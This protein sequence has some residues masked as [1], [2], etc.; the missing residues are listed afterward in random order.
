MSRKYWKNDCEIDRRKSMAQKKKKIE[1][2][3]ALSL[4]LC[5]ERPRRGTLR[6]GV[7]RRDQRAGSQ[8]WRAT[9]SEASEE[10]KG[11]RFE[12][13]KH[14]K[15]A[16]HQRG[17]AE[18]KRRRCVFP[19]SLSLSRALAH[20][21]LESTRTETG[22]CS[23]HEERRTTRKRFRARV[24]REKK[25]EGERRETMNAVFFSLFSPL[26]CASL[27][28]QLTFFFLPVAIVTRGLRSSR[29]PQEGK[30]E[31]MKEENRGRAFLQGPPSLSAPFEGGDESR[32]RNVGR[33]SS[34]VE[35]K[36]RDQGE[37][38]KSLNFF[39]LSSP[40]S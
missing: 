15:G 19:L 28:F 16:G 39:S 7:P 17:K 8:R 14:S 20:L 18:G 5:V 11:Q 2:R 12:R 10:C 32:E 22:Q 9:S 3:R 27:A 26:C 38:P 30:E 40:S 33:H 1:K 24:A 4:S 35:E 6:A 23:L 31:K 37:K 21:R 29:A 36:I 25:R 34:S 13:K